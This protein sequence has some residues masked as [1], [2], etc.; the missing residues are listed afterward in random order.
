MPSTSASEII[1]ALRKFGAEATS[2]EAKRAEG[3]LPRSV[4]ETLSSFSNTAG[5]GTLILGLDEAAGFATI[6]LADPAKLMADL[7]SMSRDEMSPPLQPAIDVLE[8]DARAVIVADIPE[9]PKNQKP[10]YVKSLGMERGSYLRV[11]ESDRRLT[12]E[13]VQQV[14]ADRG[15]P[16]FDHEVILEA[17]KDDLDKTALAAY[18][19]RARE[20]NPRVFGDESA[21]VILRMNKVL[22]RGSDGEQHPTLAGLLAMGRY[23][24][25]FFPQLNLTFVHY[26]TASG[27][28]GRDGVRFLDN[29]RVDGPIPAMAADAL[30][31]IR[32]NMSRRALVTGEGRRD[33]WEYPPEALREAVVNALVHRDLGP[34]SRGNQVQIEMYPDRLRI[35][36]PGGLFGAVNIERLGEEGRSSARNGLLMKLLEEVTVPDEDRTVCENRGSGIRAMLAA[37]RQAGMSPPSFKDSTTAFEV[38]LPNHTLLDDETVDWLRQLGR[39]G[40]RDTQCTALALMRRGEVMDNTRYRAATGITDSRAA[41]FEL[42]DLVARE[43]VAQTGTRSG[44]RYTLSGYAASARTGRRRIRPNRRRQIVDLLALHGEL[45]KSEVSERLS[46]NPKTAEHWLRTLKSEGS[47]EAT[48]PGRGSKH[49]KYRLTAAAMQGTLFDDGEE[50]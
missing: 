10:C 49:T 4:R 50:S 28:A 37:L 22:A 38:V 35:M 20:T 14:V 29:V 42:Q 27:E 41:T 39:E 46:L 8:I 40:L 45:S 15:Q 7:A 2:V 18:V 6:G 31:V 36:N 21:E 16:Q 19:Q 17:T 43:L 1:T 34:G 26:P 30:N 23:P 47:V 24:Q 44:A 25:Q 3:G 12:S 11:G 5:G 32:R 48:E 9:L 13:E 33:M